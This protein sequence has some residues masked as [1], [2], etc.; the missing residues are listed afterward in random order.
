MSQLNH[1]DP[2]TIIPSNTEQLAD[3]LVA[4]IQRASRLRPAHWSKKSNASYYTKKHGVQMKAVLDHMI[5]HKEPVI[6]RYDDPRFNDVK[7]QTLYLKI[8]QGITY[9]L[10]IYNGMD[11]EGKYEA[12]WRAI[13]CHKLHGI[14][15]I[16]EFKKNEDDNIDPMA[17]MPSTVVMNNKTWREKMEEF[18][19][20]AKVGD[21]FEQDNLAL[22]EETQQEIMDEFQQVDLIFAVRVTASRVVITKIK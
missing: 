11:P 10:D 8:N 13:K 9:L 6:W 2:T 20:D 15:I 7:P 21:R 5:L 12:V 3:K 18:L 16:F 1:Q 22:S 19:K 4:T 17:L 14:G